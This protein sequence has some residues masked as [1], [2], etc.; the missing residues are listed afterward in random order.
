MVPL[1]RKHSGYF[2]VAV[3]SLLW[4]VPAL[5]LWP[6]GVWLAALL[7]LARLLAS[8]IRNFRFGS[9]KLPGQF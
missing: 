5:G 7:C 6:L 8:R 9:M 4:T 2:K 1:G 3:V